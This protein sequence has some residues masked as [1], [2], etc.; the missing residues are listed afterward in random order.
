MTRARENEK[1]KSGEALDSDYS[2][3][4]HLKVGMQ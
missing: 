2:V 1:N 4:R 3:F